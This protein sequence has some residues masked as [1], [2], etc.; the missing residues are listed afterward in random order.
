[1]S[2]I[3]VYSCDS[4]LNPDKVSRA[5]NKI[6]EE[7]KG[8]PSSLETPLFLAYRLEE[9]SKY[10]TK[11]SEI[12]TFAKY[13][14]QYVESMVDVFLNNNEDT[15]NIFDYKEI[16]GSDPVIKISKSKKDINHGFWKITNLALVNPFIPVDER[17][18]TKDFPFKE[19]IKQVPEYS[20]QVHNSGFFNGKFDE[21]KVDE[22]LKKDQIKNDG[23]N[24]LL[25]L[26]EDPELQQAFF[27]DLQ[28]PLI[29][30]YRIQEV[31]H[32]VNQRNLEIDK[33]NKAYRDYQR[34][35]NKYT[36]R[37]EKHENLELLPEDQRY[38]PLAPD[39]IPSDEEWFMAQ[40]PKTRNQVVEFFSLQSRSKFNTTT[41]KT[42][43]ISNKN[44]IMEIP[45]VLYT[46]QKCGVS[47]EIIEEFKKSNKIYGPTIKTKV[48]TE[49]LS[50]HR[51]QLVVHS[52]K[53][54]PNP[55]PGRTTNCEKFPRDSKINGLWTK[56]EV[57]RYENHM[58]QRK[59]YYSKRAGKEVSALVAIINGF[60]HGL[61]STYNAYEFYKYFDNCTLDPMIKFD[62]RKYFRE[63]TSEDFDPHV[64]QLKLKKKVDKPDVV[65]YADFET[66]TDEEHHIP[67]MVHCIGPKIDQTYFGEDC[68]YKML[69]EINEKVG[70]VNKINKKTNELEEVVPTVR[71][72]FHNLKYDYTFIR[73][74]LKK[75]DECTKGNQLYSASGYFTSKKSNEKSKYIKIDFWDT[76]PIMRCR[77]S[78]AAEYYIGGERAKQF[79]K[80]ACPY[81][82]YTRENFKKYP[83]NWAPLEEFKKKFNS[84]KDLE[85]FNKTLPELPEKIYNKTLQEINFMEYSAFYCRQDVIIMKE[86]F[87]N[88][89][90]LFLG[91]EI[92]G[93]HGTPPFS[94]DVFRYRTIS[95]LAWAYFLK[96]SFGKYFEPPEDDKPQKNLNICEISEIERVIGRAAVRG[97]RTMMGFNQPS[98]YVSPD[99]NNPDYDVVDFDAVSL[100]PSAG[101]RSWI[102][103][104]LPHFIKPP[105]GTK[106]TRKEFLEWFDTPETKKKTKEYTDGWLFVTQLHANIPRAFP[107]ICV[108]DPKTHLN[109]YENFNHQQVETVISMTDLFNFIDFQDGEFEW[110]GAIV[111]S[112]K[113]NYNCQT[114]FKELNDF[115]KQNHN[116][117]DENGNDIPDHPIATLTKLVNNSI[118]GKSNQKIQNFEINIIDKIG[119]S[120]NR[121]A[122]AFTIRDVWQEY[123]NANAYRIIDFEPLAGNKN[124]IKV[125]QYRTD[126]SFAMIQ[127]AI[128]ILAISK[129]IIGPVLCIAEDVAKEMN[130]PGPF[131]TDTDSMHLIRKTLPETARRFEEKYGYPLIGKE[132]GQFH[133]DFDTPPNFKKDPKTGKFIEKVRGAIECY[134]CAKKVYAD[135]LIGTEDSIG[136]HKRMKGICSDLVQWDDYEKYFN[137]RPLTYDLVKAKPSFVYEEGYVKSL[138]SMIRTVM[139]RACREALKRPRQIEE[140]PVIEI[141][142]ETEE[143]DTVIEDVPAKRQ[144][145]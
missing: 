120:F 106:W 42:E 140:N 111:W 53:K 20:R 17:R 31:W 142:D 98:H 19:T 121:S 102:S 137:N 8:I 35:L 127:F 66:T 117:V 36:Q 18:L 87:E 2:I 136:Y 14:S 38:P 47:K 10:G 54:T 43:I 46:L 131:Y 84:E 41:M 23:L 141:I 97:G 104:G 45:C 125:R 75:I 105:E 134:F 22:Y 67:Y 1:M 26:I 107:M 101:A 119:W 139:S 128:T 55:V 29:S 62:I 48:I 11:L 39:P 122:Q 110:E 37:L 9:V 44:S 115:R 135:K 118:Y 81:G 71:I 109:N 25:D 3:R 5:L 145:I 34:E 24:L 68:A 95:S 103:K 144:K 93:I 21:E 143:S 33:Y 85:L 82:F 7:A 116:L 89:R 59:F 4:I 72:Y 51:I 77:L 138:P 12:T 96:K 88:I 15:I 114:P 132:L 130:L 16:M 90:K 58:F 27:D 108:K 124:H 92:E 30:T 94:I 83:N 70:T 49:I 86:A 32:V 6:E 100:Y 133:I 65:Y 99:P 74:L 50:K 69:A 78:K 80:E 126:K 123:F 79:K 40:S 113:R 73:G 60:Q 112:G 64:R 52:N 129:R 13:T 76:L 91:K 56:I 57:D 63:N 61:L 28:I